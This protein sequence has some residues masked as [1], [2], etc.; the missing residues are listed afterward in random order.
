MTHPRVRRGLNVAATT[1]CPHPV[2]GPEH[3]RPSTVRSKPF[4]SRECLTR[5]RILTMIAVP[6]VAGGVRVVATQLGKRGHPEA[7]GRAQQI[8][9]R[10]HP[11]RRAKTPRS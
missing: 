6:F 11:T 2:E 9:D 7:A 10:V 4:P 8:A 1:G 5:R 3:R